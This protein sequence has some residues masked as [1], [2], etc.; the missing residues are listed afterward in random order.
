MG[1]SQYFLFPI[2]YWLLPMVSGD[3]AG[4]AVMFT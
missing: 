1:N 4:M 2:A 3:L